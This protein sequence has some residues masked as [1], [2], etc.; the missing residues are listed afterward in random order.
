MSIAF[1]TSGNNQTS[2]RTTPSVLV[3][4][5]RNTPGSTTRKF[6]YCNRNSPNLNLTFNCV[7]NGTNFNGMKDPF[8]N[9]FF[10]TYHILNEEIPIEDFENNLNE[11]KIN[12]KA[13][14]Y[15]PFTPQQIK[16]AYSINNIIPL[17]NKRKPI[18]TIIAAYNNP[19]LARDISSF[20]RIFGLPACNYTVY[21][22]SK[23]FSLG[24]AVEVTLNVQWVYAI[25]PYA[26]IRV[27]LAQSN[28]LKHMFNAIIFANNKNNFKPAIDTDIISMSWGTE[29]TGNYSVL[30]NYFS[31]PNTIYVASS[32]NS[33][34]TSVPSSCTN[35]LSIGGTSLNLDSFYNRASEKVW[36]SSGC[37]FSKS[38]DKPIYQPS[39]LSNNK[40]LSP[41]F[42]CVGDSNTPCYIVFNNRIYSIGGTSLSAPIY[43]GMLSLVTQNRIN[44]DRFT[45]TSVQKKYNSIQPLLYDSNNSDCFYD[46]I[47]GSS[48]LY[49]AAPGFD[50]ASGK[51]TLNETIT[52]QK[53]G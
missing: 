19:Y 13:I 47:Q 44:N 35:V 45:Y 11:K 41:D 15:G 21:N 12:S 4:K 42:S 3:G 24:W 32:G 30:N 49:S 37:G 46:I 7:F 20:G 14:L 51:G 22:F 48:G 40:R 6:K 23:S 50:I 25:N 38:F 9:T 34:K 10:Q 36:S 26:Q 39:I 16:K 8:T 17:I 18:V 52:I 2:L 29:D 28:S 31:N 5:L 53:I 43:A 1:N 27:I 33:S